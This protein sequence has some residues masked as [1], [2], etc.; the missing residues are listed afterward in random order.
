MLNLQALALVNT[1]RIALRSLWLCMD[2]QNIVK[3]YQ[4]MA[5]QR[6]TRPAWTPGLLSLSTGISVGIGVIHPF[7][8]EAIAVTLNVVSFIQVQLVILQ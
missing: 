4:H 6:S 2:L 5:R 7:I 8:L 3:A 1:Q